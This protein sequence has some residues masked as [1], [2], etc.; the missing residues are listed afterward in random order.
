M[1]EKNST[2]ADI[3]AQ[4]AAVK[5]EVMRVVDDIQ[6]RKWA[7]EKALAWNSATL[8]GAKELTQYIYDFVTQKG[9]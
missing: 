9:D 5:R 6:L 3:Q 4:A 1:Q 8:D 2:G 7:A